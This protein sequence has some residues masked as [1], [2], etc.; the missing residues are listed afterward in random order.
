MYDGTPMLLT[1]ALLRKF[2]DILAD[3]G[4]ICS[5]G[6][7]VPF[8]ID[9]FDPSKAF[10]GLIFSLFFWIMSLLVSRERS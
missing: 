2:A 9:K 3:I 4:S 5:A 7:V 1:D 8:I 6:V 10:F